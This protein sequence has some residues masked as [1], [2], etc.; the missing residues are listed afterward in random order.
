MSWVGLL[1]A[2]WTVGTPTFSRDVAPILYRQCV[3]C[4][5]PGGVAPFSL[6]RFADAER[7]AALIATVTGKRYMPPWLPAE[8]H[9]QQERRLSPSRNRHAGALGRERRA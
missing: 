3:S 9:F 8:P 1:A 5:R 2:F 6:L 4:H 7:H